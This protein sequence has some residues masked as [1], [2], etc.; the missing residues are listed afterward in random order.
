MQRPAS[1]A[2]SPRKERRGNYVI[3][4]EGKGEEIMIGTRAGV[5]ARM[6]RLVGRGR[7]FQ[8]KEGERLGACSSLPRE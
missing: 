8:S 6:W 3:V 2:N 1:R 5:T 4:R 7:W